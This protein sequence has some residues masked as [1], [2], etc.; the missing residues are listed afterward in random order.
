MRTAWSSLRA[1]TWSV[2]ACSELSSRRCVNFQCFLSKAAAAWSCL[3]SRPGGPGALG[4]PPSG[5]LPVCD[6]GGWRQ[7]PPPTQVQT[8]SASAWVTGASGWFS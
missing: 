1:H 2:T 6:S 7:A 3:Q 8:L 4:G 5:R